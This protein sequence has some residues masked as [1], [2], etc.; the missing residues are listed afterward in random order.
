MDK[1]TCYNET[2]NSPVD[3]FI[4]SNCGFAMEDFVERRYDEET[5]DVGYYEFEVKYC[6]NCGAKVVENE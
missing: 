2:E 5:E 1:E 3:E 6:P 4:C